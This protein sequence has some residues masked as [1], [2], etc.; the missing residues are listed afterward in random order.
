[1]SLD[2]TGGSNVFFIGCYCYIAD[3]SKPEDVTIRIAIIDGLFHIGF[4]VGNALAGPI[5][6]KL[7]LPYNFALGILFTCISAS[8]TLIRIKE[9]LRPP[10]VAETNKKDGLEAKTCQKGTLKFVLIDDLD[11]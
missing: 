1:M 8:Y 6:T 10:N 2:L 5:K 3:I 9:S 7:G 11:F 4:Y